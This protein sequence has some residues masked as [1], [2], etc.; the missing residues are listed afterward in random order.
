VPQRRKTH[1]IQIPATERKLRLDGDRGGRR[2]IGNQIALKMCGDAC[3]RGIDALLPGYHSGAEE[4]DHIV[5]PCNDGMLIIARFLGLQLDVVDLPDDA[6][7]IKGI[8]ERSDFSGSSEGDR[9]IHTE[10]LCPR[11][12]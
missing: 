7:N 8:K 9:V 3:S 2:Q 12:L 11:C 4:A 5:L 1:E 10:C 6:T